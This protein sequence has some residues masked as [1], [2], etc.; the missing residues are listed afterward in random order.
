MAT[1]ATPYGLR[2]VNLIGGQVFAGSTRMFSIAS[3]YNTN[4][5][6]GDIVATLADGTIARATG[7]T[8][9]AAI[10]G[11]FMGCQYTDPTTGYFVNRQGYPANTAASN[12]QAYICD[13]PDALFQIQA[14]GSVPFTA[15]GANAGIVNTAANATTG[16]SL[17]ALASASVA[18]TATLPLRVVDFVNGPSSAP[19]DAFTDVIVKFNFGMHVYEQALGI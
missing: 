14:D 17:I 4:I 11:V 12:I 2:P 18:V 9:V 19:G 6:F 15:R 8:A 13:D 10:I 1:V 16:N 5:G 7:T 3:G